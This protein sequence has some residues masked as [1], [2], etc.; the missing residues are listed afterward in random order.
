MR[1]AAWLQGESEFH[2]AHATNEG[3]QRVSEGFLPSLADASGYQFAQE[4][5]TVIGVS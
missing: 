5:Q 4:V 1:L 3:S 2:S